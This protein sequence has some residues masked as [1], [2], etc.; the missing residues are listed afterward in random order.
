MWLKFLKL[1][2]IYTIQQYNLIF[3]STKELTPEAT[4]INCKIIL[5]IMTNESIFFCTRKC[6]EQPN[7]VVG[8]C[9]VNAFKS[10]LDK[11]W[12]HQSVKFDFTADLMYAAVRSLR[13]AR[14]PLQAA[15]QRKNLSSST[16]MTSDSGG[17]CPLTF[18]QGLCPL[19]P[20]WSQST[21]S[22]LTT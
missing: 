15:G 7:S 9:T 1:P 20:H 21:F 22:S 2:I 3:L 4:G 5:F 11:F 17:L 10:R 16:K 12:Q 13:S 14:L 19:D 6:L 18:H 8:A